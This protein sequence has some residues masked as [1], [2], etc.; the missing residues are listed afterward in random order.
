MQLK[1]SASPKSP[2]T[3]ASSADSRNTSK[4]EDDYDY[5]DDDFDDLEDPE[6]L[7]R[8]LSEII[9]GKRSS[10]ALIAILN[11]EN[12]DCDSVST[13][14]SSSEHSGYNCKLVKTNSFKGE[15][16]DEIV[17]NSDTRLETGAAVN[18]IDCDT[19]S[20]AS[21]KDKCAINQS[22]GSDVGNSVNTL[23]GLYSG[24]EKDI[25]S[26]AISENK[27]DHKDNK[28]SALNFVNPN[29]DIHCPGTN[30]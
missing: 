14:S 4:V 10:T 29:H 18:D 17:H 13:Q 16:I 11:R 5:N 6:S 27:S 21:L 30:S 22:T 28:D 23:T 20:S 26:S 2:N 7:N 15:K 19:G 1:M 12:S 9:E 3:S 25:K 24:S 8:T